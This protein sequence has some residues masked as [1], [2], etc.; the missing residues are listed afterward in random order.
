MEKSQ[1]KF[2]RRMVCYIGLLFDCFRRHYICKYGHRNVGT[3]IT[4]LDDGQHGGQPLG[5]GRC[6]FTSINKLFD[7]HKSIRTIGP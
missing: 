7:W 1:R 5:S 4:N 6:I 2:N 3:I